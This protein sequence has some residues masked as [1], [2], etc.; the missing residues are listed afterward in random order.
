MIFFPGDETVAATATARR[1]ECFM[2]WV[3]SIPTINTYDTDDSITKRLVPP[4]P[5]TVS[6][7]Q[8]QPVTSKNPRH[9]AAVCPCSVSTTRLIKSARVHS[10]RWL[11]FMCVLRN[12]FSM[13]WNHGEYGGKN[14]TSMSA[15]QNKIR[16]I[17]RR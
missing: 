9:C 2:T 13:G 6:E 3:L 15:A 1:C 14:Q 5:S 16:R 17:C 8:H 12:V 7:T 11:H 10:F 4:S